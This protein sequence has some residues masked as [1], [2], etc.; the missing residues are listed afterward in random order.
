[1]NDRRANQL[2]FD[3]APCPA[4]RLRL[5]CFPYAGAGSSIFRSW[6]ADVLDGIQI[7]SVQLPGRED[8]FGEAAFTRLDP[9]VEAIAHHIGPLLDLPVALF[10]HCMGALVAF[11]LARRLRRDG[12]EPIHLV[13]SALPAPRLV[14]RAPVLHTRS[15][16]EF[17][18]ALTGLEGISHDLLENPE[19]LALLLPTMR[20]DFE[21][22]ET[23][24]YRNEPPLRCRISAYAGRH[25][26]RCPSDLLGS[27]RAETS[28]KFTVRLFPGDHFFI[29]SARAAVLSAISIDL[30]GSLIAER[31]GAGVPG[32]R[33]FAN[34]P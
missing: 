18:A 27:W 22:C 8:R 1:M 7:C 25:D 30:L 32:Q 16:R 23:Y 12:C 31:S 20:A 2:W 19:F 10:G 21:V 3:C 33:D 11:E 13:V 9:L 6:R 28:A 26:P 14:A 17:V 4:P 5:F 24:R 15:T 34:N 29:D